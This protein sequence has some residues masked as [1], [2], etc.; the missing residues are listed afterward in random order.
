MSADYEY[1]D[2]WTPRRRAALAVVLWPLLITVVGVAAFLS[3]M[4][5]LPAQIATHWGSDGPDGFTARETAPW[6]TLIGLGTAWFVGGL[7]LALGG[8]DGTHRRMGVGFA[9]GMAAFIT[10]VVVGSAWVQRG[11]ADGRDA[12][13]VEDVLVTAMM[14]AIV[15][16][17]AAAFTV[18]G[19]A[20]DVVRARG[21]VPVD[22]PRAPARAGE[23]T[24]WRRIAM[25]GRGYWIFVLLLA[26]VMASVAVLTRMWAFSLLMFVLLVGVLVITAAFRVTI[27][28]DG[29]VITSL[30]GFPTWRMRLDEV[31]QARVVQV[32]PFRD[33]GGWG[34]RLGRNG[35]TGFVVRQGDAI[36]VER[37]DGTAWVVTVDDAAAGAALLNTLADRGR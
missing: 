13:G 36:E 18:P 1:P 16:G 6:F 34:Y 21:R 27:T 33:F 8:K 32:S 26:A 15:I 9:A 23:R 12:P 4:D 14:V 37:G 29:L 35:R 10:G 28:A 25:P 3:F 20:E 17:A 7:V 22:A 31:V 30:I 11:L 2:R 24:T 19:K 5:E